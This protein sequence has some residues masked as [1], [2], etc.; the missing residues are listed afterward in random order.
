MK[1]VIPKEFHRIWFC[2]NQILCSK[3]LHIKLFYSI[4]VLYNSSIFPLF[5]KSR[6]LFSVLGCAG[7]TQYHRTCT[8]ACT[9]LFCKFFQEKL[10]DTRYPRR[11]VAHHWIVL[12]PD[13][14]ISIGFLTSNKTY[15]KILTVFKTKV[16]SKL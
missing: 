8:R 1:K 11:W 13:Q 4:L 14:R 2:R 12:P 16:V 10:R 9:L 15:G 3:Q 6:V 7:N 5:P